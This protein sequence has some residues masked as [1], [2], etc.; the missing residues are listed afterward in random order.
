LGLQENLSRAKQA[1]DHV[2][3]MLPIGAQNKPSPL[4]M[5]ASL[6]ALPIAGPILAVMA[7]ADRDV[8]RQCL[9]SVRRN[10]P[11][12]QSDEERA[13]F[14]DTLAAEAARQ[15]CGNCMEQNAVALAFLKAKKFGPVDFIVF[16][17]NTHD[18]S[19]LVIGRIAGSKLNKVSTWGPAAVICDPWWPEKANRAYGAPFLK[20]KMFADFEGKL[21]LFLRWAP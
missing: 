16:R 1:V 6:V 19:F 10:V 21:D 20:Q 4:E 13:D 18:H 14:L 11:P 3:K 8:R 12:P 17:P 9:L 2:D 7:Q 5:A 15:G